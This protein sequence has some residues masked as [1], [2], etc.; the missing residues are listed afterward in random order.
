[1]FDYDELYTLQVLFTYDD[2]D[3]MV[4]HQLGKFDGRT[5]TSA[6]TYLSTSQ[7]VADATNDT[8]G[9]N[10][11]QWPDAVVGFLPVLYGFLPKGMLTSNWGYLLTSASTIAARDLSHNSYGGCQRRS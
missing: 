7:E 11:M 9:I 2:N 8:T 10:N 5:V 4:L 6:E 3:E 1:M